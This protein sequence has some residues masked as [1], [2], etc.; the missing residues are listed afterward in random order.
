[1][2]ETPDNS[3]VAIAEVAG[4]MQAEIL[5]GMLEA[6]GI[7]VM[8]S[9]ESAARAIGISMPGLG[10]VQVFVRAEQAE[11]AREILQ[12]YDAGDFEDDTFAPDLE[13]ADADDPEIDDAEKE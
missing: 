2:S 5:R 6:Q 11:A 13:N 1:M 8:L 3:I 7:H 10:L 12:E 9:E 4:D